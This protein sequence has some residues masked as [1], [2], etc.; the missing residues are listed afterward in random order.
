MAEI[1][2]ALPATI[3]LS[4]A[5]LLIAVLLGIPLGYLAARYRGPPAATSPP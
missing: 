1:G 3:E 2:R 4:V 5:A